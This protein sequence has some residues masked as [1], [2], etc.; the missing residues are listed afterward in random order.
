MREKDVKGKIRNG[1]DAFRNRHPKISHLFGKILEAT[2]I[3]MRTVL[4][5][6]AILA[7]ELCI[8]G[9]CYVAYGRW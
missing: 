2:K 7:V 3:V 5:V 8:V 4:F 6:V 1:K 9:L